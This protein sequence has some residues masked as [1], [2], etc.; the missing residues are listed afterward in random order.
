MDF[1]VVGLGKRRRRHFPSRDFCIRSLF[2]VSEAREAHRILELHW[3]R[4]GLVRAW[5]GQPDP[6]LW[7]S[8]CD[9]ALRKD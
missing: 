9:P 6:E 8:R 4:D 1:Q 2:L 3:V 7:R 5:K